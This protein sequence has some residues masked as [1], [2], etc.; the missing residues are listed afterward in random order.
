VRRI[1][2]SSDF[3]GADGAGGSARAELLVSHVATAS[4][5][6]TARPIVIEPRMTTSWRPSD[7]GGAAPVFMERTALAATQHQQH[8]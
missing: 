6:P 3:V 5:I 2:S 1:V 7:A 4:A 8:R